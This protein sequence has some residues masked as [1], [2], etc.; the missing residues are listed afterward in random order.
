MKHWLVGL[1]FLAT[2]IAAQD[3][4]HH[5]G[6]SPEVDRFYSTWLQPNEGRQRYYGC[7][8]RLDCYP[9][10]AQFRGGHWWARHRETG[11]WIIVPSHKVE[12]DQP[13]GRD[14]PDGRTHMCASPTGVVYCFVVATGT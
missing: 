12:H 6:M 2:P 3:I 1:I 7:C 14:S 13:D 9:T 11:N 8:S 4:H 10:D 5:E